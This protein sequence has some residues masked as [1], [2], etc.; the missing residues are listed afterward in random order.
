[1]KYFVIGLVVGL[2]ILPLIGAFY[3][4]TGR[5][6]V[7][8]TD[9][10]LPFERR[11]VSTARNARIR[12]EAPDRDVSGLTTA[13]LVAG[14]EI[15]KQDCAFCHGLPQQPP[16]PEGRGMFPH[17]PQLFTPRGMVTDDPAGVTYWKV[18]NGIRLSGMPSFHAALTDDQM[19]QVTALL[20]RADKL[21]PEALEALQPALV[22]LPV[23]KASGTTKAK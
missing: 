1:M 22:I 7:A 23:Q 4:M 21:P 17:A 19:W 2:L 8:A 16:S 11:I 6:P 12:R 9:R 13:D 20:N 18:D 15:Y 3:V 14:A 5:L 10:S